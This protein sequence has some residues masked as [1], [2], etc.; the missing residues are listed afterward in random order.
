MKRFSMKKM[1]WKKHFFEL[2]LYL[3]SKDNR[4]TEPGI[5]FKSN[6]RIILS[7]RHGLSR[8]DVCE[9]FVFIVLFLRYL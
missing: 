8:N 6:K 1:A 2:Y 3:F 9:V 5:Y 7:F 4:G